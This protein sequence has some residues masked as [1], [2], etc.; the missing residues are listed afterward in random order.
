MNLNRFS[1]WSGGAEEFPEECV[2][3]TLGDGG[4]AMPLPEPEE[5]HVWLLRLDTENP[6]ITDDIRLGWLDSEDRQRAER[7]VHPGAR[8]GYLWTRGMLRRLLGQY[9]QCEPSAIRLESNPHGKPRLAETGEDQ[10]LVFN[11]S[12][13]DRLAVLGFARDRPLGIDIEKSRPDRDWHRIADYC[14]SDPERDRWRRTEAARQGMEFLKY[15]TAK[16]ALVK[17]AGRGIA[18]GLR[19]VELAP[20][21]S[22][23]AILPAELGPAADWRLQGWILDDYCLA[24]ACRSP[25]RRIRFLTE[26]ITHITAANR[27]HPS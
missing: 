15:W 25:V 18:L 20:D 17:A 8:R 12:H 6:A 10:G 2:Q 9:L 7:Y 23:F 4:S 26:D 21:F 22:A 1:R 13:T 19:R 27:L 16:E 5:I 3:P 11:V 24:L 14:L